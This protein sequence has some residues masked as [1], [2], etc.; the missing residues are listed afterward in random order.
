MTLCGDQLDSKETGVRTRGLDQGS[1][2][3][4]GK[5]SGKHILPYV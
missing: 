4:K 2:I 3:G 5:L 1:E